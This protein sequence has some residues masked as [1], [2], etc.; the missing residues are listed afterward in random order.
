MSRENLMHENSQNNGQRTS[1]RTQQPNGQR[2]RQRRVNGVNTWQAG[3]SKLLLFFALLM[4]FV[5]TVGCESKDDQNLAQAQQCL[6]K[7]SPSTVDGC[8]SLIASDVSPKAYMIRCAADF[9]RNG[10]VGSRIAEAFQKIKDNGSGQNIDAMGTA[11]SF[12]AFPSMDLVNQ[13]Q[14]NCEKSS[15]PS[16]LRLVTMSSMATLLTTATAD[17]IGTPANSD[18]TYSETQ[19]KD[20]IDKFTDLS[21]ATP[22]EIEERKEQLGV[23]VQAAAPAYCAEGSAF[24]EKE[25][26]TDLLAATAGG[27]STAE[28]AEEILLRLKK[29]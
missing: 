5:G 29:E 12:M 8:T 11:L 17:L 18:G 20:A 28:I 3:A 14:S 24:S 13:A 15:V 2:D 16:M 21:T 26:C 23:I 25:M 22:A 19:I 10:F 4:T 27:K 7:A 9:I 1:Q 6:D